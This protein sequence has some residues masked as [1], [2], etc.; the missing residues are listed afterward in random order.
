MFTY[1]IY[2]LY[3]FGG[4]KCIRIMA[5]PVLYKLVAMAALV[6]IIVVMLDIAADLLVTCYLWW[7]SKGLYNCESRQIDTGQGYDIQTGS[8]QYG[9]RLTGRRGSWKTVTT[10]DGTFGHS[11]GVVQRFGGLCGKIRMRG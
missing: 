11:L 5:M 9:A 3:V 4:K 7:L 2:V 8:C 6:V 1:M 10:F